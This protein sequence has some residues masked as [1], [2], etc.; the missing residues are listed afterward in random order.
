[1]IL[2]SPPFIFFVFLRFAYLFLVCYKNCVQ[3]SSGSYSVTFGTEAH[4]KKNRRK[5]IEIKS[6]HKTTIDDE[7][8]EES[9]LKLL[10]AQR[11]Q[12]I[13]VEMLPSRRYT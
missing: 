13:S 1:M 3:L 7:E 11:A 2:L 5:E 10:K 12:I 6:A 9:W 8:D 4:K